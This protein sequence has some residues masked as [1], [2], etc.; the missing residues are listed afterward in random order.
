MRGIIFVE[1]PSA[2]EEEA[3]AAYS[4]MC[5]P[6]NGSYHNQEGHLGKEI[7]V[8]TVSRRRHNRSFVTTKSFSLAG[9]FVPAFSFVSPKLF[10]ARLGSVKTTD[11]S[12]LI[13][14]A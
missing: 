1:L 10:V 5:G 14:T 6:N 3:I 4:S 2:P 11:V 8:S 13:L 12:R 9:K 7:E